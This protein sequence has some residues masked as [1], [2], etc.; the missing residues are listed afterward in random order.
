MSQDNQNS[1]SSSSPSRNENQSCPRQ[2]QK[3]QPFWKAKTIQI[4]KG[5]IALLETT[6]EKLETESSTTAEKTP[7]FLQP[8]QS[9]WGGLLTKIR[10]VLPGN[11]N[12]KLSDTGLIVLIV[13]IAVILVWIISNILTAKPTPVATVPPTPQGTPS[14]AITAP[15]K[16]LPLGEETTSPTPQPE[17]QVTSTPTPT[18]ELTPEQKL[19]A[20]IENQI[21]QKSDRLAPGLIK[22]IIANFLTSTLTIKISDDWYTLEESKQNNLA[23]RILQHS[24]ELDFTHL[25]IIDSQNK[26][27]ARNPVIGNEM[28]IFR[29]R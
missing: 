10:S 21:V 25:E 7:S 9:G 12:A 16:S 11:W 23:A 17:P 20:V 18:L 8:L 5:A 22:S 3:V 26:L 15:L 19:I 2:Y 29:R 24:Q 27:V 14:P 6:V 28:V 1:Q 4:L 13:A